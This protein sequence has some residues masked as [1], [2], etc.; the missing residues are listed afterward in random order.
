MKGSTKRKENDDIDCG[1]NKHWSA[2]LKLA[3]SQLGAL[4]KALKGLVEFDCMPLGNLI[5]RAL[6]V[7]TSVERSDAPW[8]VL[9]E[10]NSCIFALVKSL[11]V[12]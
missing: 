6:A 4:I 7:G 3:L 11:S 2:T 12:K 8:S 1:F 5:A 9:D 10:C